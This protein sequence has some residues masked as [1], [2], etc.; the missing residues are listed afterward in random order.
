[1]NMNIGDKVRLLHGKE[2]GII[3]RFIDNRLVEIEIEDG[4]LIPVLKKEIVPV[5]VEERRSDS[6]TARPVFMTDEAITSRENIQNEGIFL[7][8]QEVNGL[9]TAWIINNTYNTVLFTIHKQKA[10]GI[11]GISHGILKKLTY[12]KIEDW[13]ASRLP[14]FPSYILDFL[15]YFED[16]EIYSGPLSQRVN[17]DIKVLNKDKKDIPILKVKGIIIPLGKSHFDIDAEALKNAMFSKEISE[18]LKDKT[19]GS[20]TQEID[21][22]IEAL[23]E[24]ISGLGND[25]ILEIQLRH[26]ENA[27]EKAV[28]KGIDEITFI[29]GVGNGILRNKIHKK[30]SQYPHIRYFEDAMKEKFGFGATK[31]HLK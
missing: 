21:L 27:L 10:E 1:M 15:E 2:E 4:F 20:G 6:S 7:A 9:Y 19:H 24:D 14:I 26:F 12:A 18:N 29:H 23:R 13:P 17:V 31:V 28:I 16:A 11:R 3:R 8:I 30:L 22:H 25:E 5:S